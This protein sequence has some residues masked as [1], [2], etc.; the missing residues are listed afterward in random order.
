MVIPLSLS[1]GALSIFAK[2]TASPPNTSA[3]TFVKAAVSVVL[4]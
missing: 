3:A 1:S 4:P 2:S